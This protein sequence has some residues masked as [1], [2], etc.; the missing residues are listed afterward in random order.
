MSRA[1]H[2]PGAFQRTHGELPETLTRYIAYHV[3]VEH[4]RKKIVSASIYP[5]LLLIVGGAVML[6][7][8]GYV[9]PKFSQVYEDIGH[10]LP[11]LSQLLMLW[12]RFLAAHQATLAVAA[13]AAIALLVLAIRHAGVR[14]RLGGLLARLPAVRERVFLYQLA[15]FYR[16]LG[17]TLRGGIPILVSLDMVQGLLTGT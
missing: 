10:N 13:A 8:L 15:R 2:R 9:V 17:M 7:L 3:Q 14:A 5:A 12:G 6:F 1:L 16:S 11:W 4:I